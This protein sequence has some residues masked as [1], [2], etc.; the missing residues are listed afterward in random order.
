MF[1]FLT[2]LNYLFLTTI[3]YTKSNTQAI[4]LGIPIWALQLQRNP[5]GSCQL[6]HHHPRQSL[7]AA[8]MGLLLPRW[9]LYWTRPQPLSLL[10]IYKVSGSTIMS[11]PI[12]FHHHYLPSPILSLEDKLLHAFQA[13]SSTVLCTTHQP[14]NNQ[15]ATIQALWKILHHDKQL[16][17][18]AGVGPPPGVHLLT[19]PRVQLPTTNLPLHTPFPLPSTYDGWMT[20]P[21]QQCSLQPHE[22]STELSITMH[23]QS[24]LRNTF[25]ALAASCTACPRHSYRCQA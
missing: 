24:N 14:A 5:Y 23:T 25:A 7:V 4:C 21:L 13:N 18:P 9:V 12:K 6:S 17:A 19:L 2:S 11:D 15:L 22:H 1:V 20:L 10:Q 3:A 16:V 8:F